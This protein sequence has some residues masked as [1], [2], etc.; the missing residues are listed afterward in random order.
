MTHL[1]PY[2]AVLALLFVALSWRTIGLRRRYRVAVGDGGHPELLRAMRVHANFAEYAPLSLGLILMVELQGS[3]S[4][5]VHAL[6]VAL[7]VG[8]G[9]HAWGVSQTAENFRFRI[10]GMM[11][12]LGVLSISAL[13][14]LRRTLWVMWL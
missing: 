9:S 11:L 5:L 13:E 14:L 8:R 3:P 2:A 4:W 6:G 1:A 10:T 7:V 12:T